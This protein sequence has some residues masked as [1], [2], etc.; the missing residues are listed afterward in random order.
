VTGGPPV[1]PLAATGEP[2]R[3]VV[4]D[5]EPRYRQAI[6]VPDGLDLAL[7]GSYGTVEAF[8]AIHRQRCHVVVLDLCLNRQ[9]GDK[10]VLQ[11][12]RA[13]RQL[14]GQ[15]SQR[16]VVYSAD[17]RPEPLARCVAA[18]AAGYISKYDDSPAL[19]RAVDEIGRHGH[20]ISDLLHEA[21]RK[22]AARC[23]D[24][25]LSDTLEE[26]LALLE[27]GLSDLEIAKERQ[28]SARTIEDH[29][30]KIL[31]IFGTTMEARH[32][33]FAELSRDLGIRP[34]DLVNDQPGQ[35]PARGLIARAMP[36][37]R[38][39]KAQTSD[40]PSPPNPPPR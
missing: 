6:D 26:T 17:E 9:T 11:G 20:I 4:I 36:W 37:V 18:G 16:V 13:I 1:L 29:K 14:T 30:R 23:R 27:T 31:E 33:G 21:L 5:D 40:K 25:R 35:R 28:L 15:L 12:V 10:A 38:S 34:G 3:Y 8:I 2:V 24:I 19:A 7:V 22:L 39:L 32:Q